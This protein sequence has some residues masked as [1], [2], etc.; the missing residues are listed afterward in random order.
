MQ[1]ENNDVVM[2]FFYDVLTVRRTVFMLE[3][4]TAAQGFKWL[5]IMTQII[6]L[7]AFCRIGIVVSVLSKSLKKF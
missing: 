1:D 3:Y 7:C 5:Q 4:R 2:V 6:L